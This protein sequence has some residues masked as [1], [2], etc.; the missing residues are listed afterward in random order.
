MHKTKYIFLAREHVVLS[1]RQFFIEKNFEEVINPIL[2]FSIPLEENLYSFTTQWTY[3]D[4]KQKLFLP[5]SPEASLKHIL[6]LGINKCFSIGRSFRNN[7]P[8]DINHNPEFLMLEWYEKNA[9]YTKIMKTLEELI[10]YLLENHTKYKNKL[11]FQNKEYD[12]ETPWPK[13]SYI[14][15]FKK[16]LN[17]DENDLENFNQLLN[18]AKNKGYNIDYKT[19]LSELIDQL[20][21]NEISKY[22]PQ[23]KAYF[24]YDFPAI[25]SRLC[26]T[27]EKNHKIANRFEMYIGDIEIANGND[28]ETDAIKIKNYFLDEYKKRQELNLPIHA[29]SKTFIKDLKKLKNQKIAGIGVGIDRL[30]MLLYNQDSIAKINEFA[31]KNNL[32]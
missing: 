28:E 20:F 27:N 29:Y 16:Y 22:L 13:F 18:L 10:I 25:T 32:N 6:A 21:L 8:S 9:D 23:N 4:K 24:L 19:T 15:L 7:E 30:A 11:I 3:L 12:L 31:L 2:N 14:N 17:L 26:K 1:I 5:T